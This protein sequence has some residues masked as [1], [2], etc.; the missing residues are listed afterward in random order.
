MHELERTFLAKYL[1]NNLEKC[2]SK[3]IFDIYL[4]KSSAHPKIRIRK[5]GDKYEITK[6]TAVKE[7]DYSHF[8]EETIKLTDEEFRNLKN[9]D[10]KKIRKIRHDYDYNGQ[11][12][13]ID[14]FQ[15]NL[16]GLVLI[17][18]EF[19]NKETMDSF[20]MPKF[21]LADV[22]QDDF[23]AGGML[24]GKSYKEIEEKLALYDYKEL[25]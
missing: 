6:K 8:L 7:G 1:P 9:I 10:G 15:D 2:F 18:F 3:E 14:V 22:T 17:D 24:C 13:E 4:P 5:N 20:K 11:K 12:A 19:D 23:I 16:S 21:C 25:A